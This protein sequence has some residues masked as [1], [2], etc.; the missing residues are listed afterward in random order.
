MVVTDIRITELRTTQ[1]NVAI[2]TL[3]YCIIR[4]INSIQ[5]RKFNFIELSRKE[6]L[7]CVHK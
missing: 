7:L 5:K 2:I 6:H 4:I 1:P 3:G